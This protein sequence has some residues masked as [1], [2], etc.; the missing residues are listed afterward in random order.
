MIIDNNAKKM[1][2]CEKMNLLKTLQSNILVADGA[3]GTMLYSHGVDRSY[4]EMNLTHSE[5]VYTIHRA[6][7]EAGAQVIQTNTYAANEEKLKRYGIEALSKQINREGVKIAKAAAKDEA[8]VLGTVGGIRGFN[9]RDHD[10]KD[11]E[12]MISE[13]VYW[14]ASEQIDGLLFETYYDLDE[15][16]TAVKVAK[17]LTNLPVIAQLSLHEVGV[18]QGGKRVNDAFLELIDL[19]ADVVGLNCRLGPLH[20]LKSLKEVPL[21]PNAF[22]SAYPNA[23]LPQYTDGKFSYSENPEYFGKMAKEFIKEGVRLI[24]GCCGTTPEHIRYMAEAVHNL[25]PLEEK[26]WIE[27]KEE[28]EVIHVIEERTDEPLQQMVKEKRSIIVELDTPKRLNIESFVQGAKALHDAGAEAITM[29]DNSLATPRVSNMAMASILKQQHYIRS[30]VHLTCRDRNLIGLQSHLLGLH[31]LGIRDLLA[32]TGDPARVGDFPGATSVYDLSSFD[33]IRFIKQL[34]EGLS[35][36][37][38]S[39]GGKTDFSVGAAFNPNVKYLDK[40]VL[41]MEKKIEA[42]ADFF[43]TQPVYSEEKIREVYELTKHIKQPIYLGIMPFTGI[44]NAEFLHNEVP[45]IQLTDSILQRM[46]YC[47]TKEE[48][49]RESLAIS[50]SLLDVAMEYFNGI[51]LITPFN[52]YDLTVE[53]TNYIKEKDKQKQ[54]LI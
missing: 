27:V 19:G 5:E 49:T 38:Q 41:R 21:Y 52:R 54:L 29:A 10:L 47:Q 12:K 30:L 17:K 26:K 16:K 6:Y 15:L 33:L 40:A 7:I 42:G 46:R 50:R 25:K 37:G 8:F 53:L 3:M 9:K 18:L 28:K 1:I 20:M 34:N 11:L 23:S 4:E 45:G 44:R 35:F 36:S 39:L 13:Q 2:G 48:A 24:G 32:I 43:M 14:L 22:L 51:Y 31:A